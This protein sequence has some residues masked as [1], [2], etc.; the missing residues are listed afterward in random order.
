[1]SELNIDE[2]FKVTVNKQEVQYVRCC[3]CGLVHEVYYDIYENSID[4][5]FTRDEGRTIKRRAE[6]KTAVNRKEK[7]PCE[8]LDED[9]LKHPL[10]PPV[11]EKVNCDKFETL[12]HVMTEKV[13]KNVRPEQNTD[14]R[15][16]SPY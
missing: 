12:G 8:E 4:M 3:D 14:S 6:M 5:V 1:M 15:K 7:S 13:I 11:E 16:K 2:N 9:R 10:N